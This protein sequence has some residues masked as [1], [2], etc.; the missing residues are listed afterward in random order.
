M[1]GEYDRPLSLTTMTSGLPAVAMLFSASQHI[2]P[3]SAPSPTTATTLRDSPR[4][5]YALA[6]P[7]A[8]DRAVE[9]CEFS[10]MS[11]SLS[12]WLG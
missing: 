9:A 8:Y 10:M 6:S 5:A 3:V 11:C 12:A 1:V 7:S 4:S 2:P